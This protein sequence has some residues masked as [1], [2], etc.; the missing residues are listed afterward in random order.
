MSCQRAKEMVAQLLHEKDILSS[1][2]SNDG[3]GDY[4]QRA[5]LELPV[6]RSVI[7]IVIGK[8]GEMIKK[9]QQDSGARI[10]FKPED[11]MGGP[12]RIC[13]IMG[14]QDQTQ[15]A[16]AMIQDI[17]QNALQKQSAGGGDA[18]SW[19]KS[20]RSGGGMS[21]FGNGVTDETTYSVPAD[22]CGLVIGKGGE[23]IREICRQSGAHV[24]L[25][26]D[27]SA[28]SMERIF[29]IQG[30]QDQI[31]QAIQLVCEKAGITPPRDGA[32]MAMP[33]GVTNMPA[34]A[35]MMTAQASLPNVYGQATSQAQQPLQQFALQTPYQYQAY[36]QPTAALT[37]D[38]QNMSKQAVDVNAAA[39]AAYYAQYYNQLT[40]AQQQQPAVSATQLQQ[41]PQAQSQYGAMLQRSTVTPQPSL[42]GLQQQ[43]LA[44]TSTAAT[45]YSAAWADYYRQQQQQHAIL[46]QSALQPQQ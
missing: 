46:M 34:V 33:G 20:P 9:V 14:S 22:K 10:Q 39:W 16:T 25:N 17:V 3:F 40:A 24:E 12:N 28:N 21:K 44:A 7:G 13:C 6:P 43:G 23:T 37:N 32:A 18:G 36:N 11:E 2:G 8:G 29:R 45:D 26:R 5:T 42:A 31:R 35:N 41:Q 1:G 15:T 38:I 27:A 4:G 30:S 19:N